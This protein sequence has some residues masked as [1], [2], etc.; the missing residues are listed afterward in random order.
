MIIQTGTVC[1]F[2]GY[3][4]FC[5]Q[6]SDRWLPGGDFLESRCESWS[7]PGFKKKLLHL[8]S[9]WSPVRGTWWSRP[10]HGRDS[11]RSRQQNRRGIQRRCGQERLGCWSRRRWE[12]RGKDENEEK[13]F[14]RWSFLPTCRDP[15]LCECKVEWWLPGKVG[16]LVWGGGRS[17]P[18][19]CCTCYI[20]MGWNVRGGP[21]LQANLANM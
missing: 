7:M 13:Q 19:E 16:W 6:I 17:K 2:S 20:A 5:T 8:K 3:F 10:K 4:I 15:E 12:W 14:Q 21:H 18:S 1:K 9:C 11:T